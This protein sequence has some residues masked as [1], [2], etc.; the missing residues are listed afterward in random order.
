MGDQAQSEAAAL[1]LVD[2]PDHQAVALL[3][4]QAESD[5]G[6]ILLWL[7]GRGALTVRAYRADVEAFLLWAGKPLQQVTLADLQGWHE[8][9]GGMAPASRCRKLAAVK[10]LLGF[11]HRLGY[12]AADAGRPL[13]L[14]KVKD[15]LAERIIEEAE[16]QRLLA[17]EPSPRNHLVLRLMYGCGLRISEVCQLCWRDLKGTK[18]GG[19]ATVFGKGGRTRAVL[20]QPKLWRQL[21]ALRGGAGPEDAVF[22]SR[23]GGGL[24]ASQVHRIVKAAAARAG[25][26]AELSAHW[27]RHAHASHSLDRGAPVHVVQQSLGHGSLTTTTRYAHVRPGDGSARYLPD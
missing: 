19:Q 14:P 15:T 23:K 2:A 27:L 5:A 8:A 9:I 11:G 7:A 26:P 6:L 1:V 4:R 18:A 24:D 21:L 10:S 20:I 16:A 17:A 3:P 22:R 13:R 12:L 25:L